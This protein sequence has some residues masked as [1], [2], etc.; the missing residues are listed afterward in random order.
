MDKPLTTGA[1]DAIVVVS[2][3][4]TAVDCNN[5]FARLCGMPAGML[6]GQPLSVCA[7][8]LAT[9]LGS[10]RSDVLTVADQ[11]F[12]LDDQPFTAGTAT[13]DRIIR[14]RSARMHEAA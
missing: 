5:A 3:T 1:V 12:E 10:N 11:M 9:L 8:E 14:L 4:G 2:A 13:G 6:L 7:P